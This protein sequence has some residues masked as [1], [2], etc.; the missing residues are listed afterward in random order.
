MRDFYHA[1]QGEEESIPSFATNMEGLLSQ[2][3]DKFPEKFTHTKEQKLLK[4]RLFHGCR[5]NIRDSVKYCFTN[6]Q[7]DYMQFLEECRK[8]EDEGK[9]G[10]VKINPS[11]PRW[12]LP[13][14]HP[15]EKMSSLNSS[16]ISSTKLILWW[17]R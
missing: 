7:V 5:K 6:P 10:Q 8:I 12:Q 11:K 1:D 16:D 3:R 17:A 9:V 4:D 14:Y 15:P 13:Q 2:V